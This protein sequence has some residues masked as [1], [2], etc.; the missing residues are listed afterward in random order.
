VFAKWAL[1]WTLAFL[2]PYMVLIY[3]VKS[4]YNLKVVCKNVLRL[5]VAYVIWYVVTYILNW[6]EH[7]TGDCEGTDFY[8]GK[9]ECR[10][11]GLI[12]NGVDI[13]GH[14]FLLSYCTL[15]ISEEIQVVKFWTNEM[16]CSD[17]ES[18]RANESIS[19][20]ET[21]ALNERESRPNER[22]L[23]DMKKQPVVVRYLCIIL[24]VICCLLM[25][26][27]LILLAFTSM[28]FHTVNS[29]VLGI[30]LGLS[31]WYYTYQVNWWSKYFPGYAT[32][33]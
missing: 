7:L 6:I 21:M 4:R 5:V 3:W 16:I 18:N 33:Y 27:W 11:E 8:E 25:S 15:I 26:M 1:G 31:A 14:S 19:S 30:I 10:R 13:S 2:T 29:K 12:W 20:N 9:E 32:K 24:Y 23:F 22:F 17:N 28:Y